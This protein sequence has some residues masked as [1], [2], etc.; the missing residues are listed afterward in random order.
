MMKNYLLPSIS[1]V[2]LA[3][4]IIKIPGKNS[5]RHSASDTM[6]RISLHEHFITAAKLKEIADQDGGV[7]LVDLRP[8]Q[9]FLNGQLPEAINLPSD[10]LNLGLIHDAFEGVRTSVLY[11]AGS[12]VSAQLWVLLT[13]MGFENVYVLDTGNTVVPS[14]EIPAFKFMQ[15]TSRTK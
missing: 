4:I 13:Q 6:D 7:L 14:D 9:E 12:P 1:V 15:D 2:L 11:S 10:E 8:R 5:F 3:L